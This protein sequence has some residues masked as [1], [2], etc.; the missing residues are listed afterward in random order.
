M[1]RW[2]WNIDTSG[3]AT[4]AEAHQLFFAAFH[5][6]N[7]H[8]PLVD[9]TCNS[10]PVYID[11]HTPFAP[12]D[13]SHHHPQSMPHWISVFCWAERL[14]LQHSFIRF[15]L[16]C[17]RASPWITSFSLSLNLHSL[18]LSPDNHPGSAPILQLAAS[19]F[20]NVGAPPH[21][22]KSKFQRR[23]RTVILFCRPVNTY[24]WAMVCFCVSVPGPTFGYML[25]VVVHHVL[26]LDEAF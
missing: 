5:C 23:L 8:R 4:T 14:P 9:P 3:S 20:P 25:S 10:S 18:L 11:S 6:T 16:Y 13:Y 12:L 1:N 21:E 15:V 2:E 26:P 24:S 7:L 22:T 17:E 19:S